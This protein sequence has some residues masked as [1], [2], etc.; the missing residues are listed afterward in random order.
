MKGY[1][2]NQKPKKIILLSPLAIT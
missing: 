2:D 1:D